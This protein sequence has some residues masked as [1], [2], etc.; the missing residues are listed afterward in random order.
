M[1]Y[2]VLCKGK[3]RWGMMYCVKENKRRLGDLSKQLYRWG[4]KRRF[5]TCKAQLCCF[6]RNDFD[7]NAWNDMKH[8]QPMEH[9]IQI[10]VIFLTIQNFTWFQKQQEMAN[11]EW[12]EKPKLPSSPLH[13]KHKIICFKFYSILNM[14][15]E[16]AFSKL[17]KRFK[18]FLLRIKKSYTWVI[19]FTHN[20]G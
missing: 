17:Y 10:T 16:K 6:L 18:A 14:V 8:E 4:W 20:F 2:D 13:S 11:M 7:T 19:F 3:R 12:V 9:Y 5:G 1:R 15:A